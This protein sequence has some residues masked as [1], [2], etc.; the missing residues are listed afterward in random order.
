MSVTV[1]LVEY[2]YKRPC[3]SHFLAEQ[4]LL[5]M[6]HEETLLWALYQ[7]YRLYRSG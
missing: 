6:T 1:P 3:S 2:M 7:M 4:G 5:M